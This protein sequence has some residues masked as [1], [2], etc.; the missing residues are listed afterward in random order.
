MTRSVK[1]ATPETPAQVAEWTRRNS[2]YAEALGCYRCA[3]QLAWGHQVGFGRLEHQPCDDCAPLVAAFPQPTGG[4][5]R[6]LPRGVR[7]LPPA[8]LTARPRVTVLG[9]ADSRAGGQPV[10]PQ[11]VA[12]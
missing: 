3:A 9:D 1:T 8:R 11:G 12:A 7:S 2:Q 10:A 5:W 4:A 6:A